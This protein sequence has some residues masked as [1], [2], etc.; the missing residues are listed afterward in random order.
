MKNIL[1]IFIVFISLLIHFKVYAEPV[2]ES[3][4]SVAGENHT[5][6]GIAFNPD[7]TASE[8]ETTIQVTPTPDE[9]P[10]PDDAP[11]P[12]MTPEQEG[13]KRRRRRRKS[14]KKR[15]GGC[16]CASPMTGGKRKRRRRRTHV[17]S[18]TTRRHPQLDGQYTDTRRPCPHLQNRAA[19]TGP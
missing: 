4:F 8:G 6:T 5:A 2:F 18:A 15:G 19:A 9:T 7:A 17:P 1:Y 16:G 11:T 13:G 10:S 3:N 12:P 14:K